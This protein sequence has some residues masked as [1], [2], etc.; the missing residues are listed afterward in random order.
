MILDYA[1]LTDE[2]L[3]IELQGG[4]HDA[5]AQL[6]ERHNSRCVR[7]A[8]KILGN[9]ADAEEEVQNT[10]MRVYQHI[11]Q[12]QNRAKFTHWL[13]QIVDNQCRM[14]FRKSR[15]MPLVPIRE[16]FD[17]EKPGLQ[18]VEE[19]PT[20]EQQMIRLERITVANQRIDALPPA[21]REILVLRYERGWAIEHIA[22]YLGLSL[23]G[24][25]SRLHRGRAKLRHRAQ[26]ATRRRSLLRS[27]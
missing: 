4:D 8:C 15:N 11:G 16:E 17:E 19:G 21:Y 13:M 9:F 10:F 7:Y 26:S 25:K 2:A 6:M 12:F 24:T 14:R 18:I 22:T 5:F 20:P 23:A 27:A 1:A 3:A